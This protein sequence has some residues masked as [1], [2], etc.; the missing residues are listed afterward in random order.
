MPTMRIILQPTEHSKPA[1][2]AQGAACK[3][4]RDIPQIR[5]RKWSEK[6]R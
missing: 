2:Q 6:E 5:E 4:G 1:A 3:Q